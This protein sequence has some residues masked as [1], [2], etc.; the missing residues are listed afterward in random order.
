MIASC[1][2]T[3]I[4]ELQGDGWTYFSQLDSGPQK[5]ILCE[6]S[7]A[8]SMCNWLHNDSGEGKGIETKFIQIHFHKKMRRVVRIVPISNFPGNVVLERFRF[9]GFGRVL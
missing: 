8:Q 5:A 2:G 7:Q 3:F 9:W 6:Y 1:G 4:T